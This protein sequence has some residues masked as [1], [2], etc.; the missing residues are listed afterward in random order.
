MYDGEE[1]LAVDVRPASNVL[2]LDT[3]DKGHREARVKSRDIQRLAKMHADSTKHYPGRAK[4]S[5]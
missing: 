3:T 5:K 2:K 1:N 4:Q